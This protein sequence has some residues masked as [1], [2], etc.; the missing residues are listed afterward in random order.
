MLF[1]KTTIAYQPD[2]PFLGDLCN[3]SGH[4]GAGVPKHHHHGV[5]TVHHVKEELCCYCHV[6][7]EQ[8]TTRPGCVCLFVFWFDLML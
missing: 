2:V 6:A 3:G 8:K 4:G 1:N 7:L 5:V